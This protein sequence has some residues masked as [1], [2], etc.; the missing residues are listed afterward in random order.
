M[1]LYIQLMSD[2]LDYIEEHI[3]E[4]LSLESLSRQFAISTY[5]FNRL[6]S[7][8]IGTSP[9]Q[10][11]LGRK[12]SLAA[13]KLSPTS[14]SVIDTAFEFGFEYPEVFSRAFKKYFG[15]SPNAYRNQ[16]RH[17]PFCE[18]AKIISRE[19]VNTQGTLIV[20]G[21]C[22]HH[23]SQILAGLSIE[24]NLVQDNYKTQLRQAGNHFLET[25]QLLPHLDQ[26]RF[27][28]LVNCHGKDDGTYTVFFGKQTT[29]T[30]Q[31]SQLVQRLFPGGWYA[32]F[33]YYGDLI[34]M[35]ET[36]V[37]DLYR[38]IIIK[39]IALD[40]DRIGM[41]SIFKTDPR[42]SQQVELLVPIISPG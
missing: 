6:F 35:R 7:I 4:P 13:Q 28:S 31:P 17:L 16:P 14:S 25:S 38:W 8:M 23:E 36:F 9:K 29:T 24:V 34:E 1:S 30:V 33:Q 41:I 26:D 20:K 2:T 32:S 5:H 22:V 3:R 18:K 15:V 40:S 39:E 27:F 12:L 42:Y 10:Y 11:I 21:R 37:N 19:L